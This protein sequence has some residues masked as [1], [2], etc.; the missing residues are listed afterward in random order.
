MGFSDA[1]LVNLALMD[2]VGHRPL[3][4]LIHRMFEAKRAK[5][6]SGS[7]LVELKAVNVP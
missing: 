1:E 2:Q 3:S 5:S 7:C 4:S 6:N